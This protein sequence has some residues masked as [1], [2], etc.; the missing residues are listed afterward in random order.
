MNRKMVLVVS[1]FIVSSLGAIWFG[2][3][4]CKL[5]EQLEKSTTTTGRLRHLVPERFV[6]SHGVDKQQLSESIANASYPLVRSEGND[7]LRIGRIVLLGK[8]GDSYI[9]FTTSCAATNQHPWP[10]RDQEQEYNQVLVVRLHNGTNRVFLLPETNLQPERGFAWAKHFNTPVNIETPSKLETIN[11]KIPANIERQRLN[12][13]VQKG[14]HIDFTKVSGEWTIGGLYRMCDAAGY[15]RMGK[16]NAKY[17]PYNRAALVLTQDIDSQTKPIWVYSKDKLASVLIRENG[18]LY[19]GINDDTKLSNNKGAIQV[20]MQIRSSNFQGSL[21]EVAKI[22]QFGRNDI[23]LVAFPIS[24]N[25]LPDGLPTLGVKSPTETLNNILASSTNIYGEKFFLYCE[26]C[27]ALNQEVPQ[28]IQEARDEE[29]YIAFEKGKKEGVAIFI[30]GIIKPLTGIA[31]NLV[32]EILPGNMSDHLVNAVSGMV[33]NLIVS[34]F[35]DPIWQDKIRPSLASLNPHS[36]AFLPETLKGNSAS[37]YFFSDF[38]PRVLASNEVK[39]LIGRTLQ[40]ADGTSFDLAGLGSV[41][42]EKAKSLLS[43]LLKPDS[44]ITLVPYKQ[45]DGANK[46]HLLIDGQY[47][48]QMLIEDGFAEFDA[49]DKNFPF[50][51]EFQEK[52]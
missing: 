30:T 51:Q 23:V 13:T 7:K 26:K 29:Y 37:S 36:A 27:D 20:E 41:D 19:L 38:L 45:D 17:S 8:E 25:G 9:G 12:I 40:L 35:V 22:Q 46:G 2:F 43:G 42:I 28:K 48:N 47:F 50:K 4:T 44:K 31:G 33:S 39:E 49:S 34:S 24:N 6:L 52:M 10:E 5:S 11:L 1:L 18:P 32:R 14:D 21:Q 16:S 15:K 3:Q